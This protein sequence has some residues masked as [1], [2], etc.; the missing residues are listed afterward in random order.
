MLTHDSTKFDENIIVLVLLISYLG[1]TISTESDHSDPFN[2]FYFTA[3][4]VMSQV[5]QPKSVEAPLKS[6]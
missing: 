2:C 1:T 5:L 3:T 6:Y 4:H